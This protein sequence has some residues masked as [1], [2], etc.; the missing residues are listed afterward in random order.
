MRVS[1]SDVGE[2]IYPRSAHLEYAEA[3]T[4]KENKKVPIHNWFAFRHAFGP[5]LV[6]EIVS[7][8]GLRTDARVLD[9]FCGSGTRL[10]ACKELRQYFLS[11]FKGWVTKKGG[12]LT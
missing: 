3:V 11:L 8:L 5:S 12:C 9:P 10:L 2:I 6:K 7:E 1:K 4:T